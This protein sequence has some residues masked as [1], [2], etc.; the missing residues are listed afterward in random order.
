MKIVLKGVPPIL[1]QFAGR[2]NTWEYRAAKKQWSDAVYI[3]CMAQR[4][5][6]TLEKAMVRIDYYFPDRRRHDADNYSGKFL[7]DGLTRAKVIQDDDFAHLCTAAHG[8][9][10]RENPRTEI[11]VVRMV[12]E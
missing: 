4:P 6:E 1:N 11:T 9:V 5:Y 8:H 3:A 7:H 2:K 12:P 10:D